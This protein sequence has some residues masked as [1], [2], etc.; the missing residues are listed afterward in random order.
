MREGRARVPSAIQKQGAPAPTPVQHLAAG[1][2]GNNEPLPK[3]STQR[4]SEHPDTDGRPAHRCTGETPIR[5]APPACSAMSAAA[6]PLP[7][8]G[9]KYF[10]EIALHRLIRLQQ[11][12]FKQKEGDARNAPI[13][14][15]VE[16]NLRTLFPNNSFHCWV[17]CGNAGTTCIRACEA[18]LSRPASGH[19]TA[20]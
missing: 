13:A 14:T 7:T 1:R 16:S 5:G 2:G 17:R 18:G 3:S 4:R 8:G 12:L 6:K 11:H 19:Q 20:A 10:A 15:L 9:A